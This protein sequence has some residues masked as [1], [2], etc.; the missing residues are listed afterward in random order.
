MDKL[1]EVLFIGE[2]YNL[3]LCRNLFARTCN[4]I[5]C[6]LYL[7]SLYNTH[8]CVSM[9]APDTGSR[10]GGAVVSVLAIS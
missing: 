10:L 6:P 5:T 8:C 2:W 4:E 1:F 9:A 7:Y 3:F